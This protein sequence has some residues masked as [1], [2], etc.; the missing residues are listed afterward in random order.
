MKILD[1]RYLLY[2]DQREEDL[3]IRNGLGDLENWIRNQMNPI[4]PFITGDEQ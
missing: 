4:M 3:H 1:M 2:C